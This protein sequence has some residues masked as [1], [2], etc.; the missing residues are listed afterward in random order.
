MEEALI[1]LLLG[2][3][4]VSAIVGDRIFWG[5]RKQGSPLPALVLNRISSVHSYT[6]DGPVDLSQSRIQIDCYAQTFGQTRALSRAVYAP[7]NGKRAVHE[8]VSFEGVFADSER[9]NPV[10]DDS[11]T[12]RTSIDFM[13]WSK[14]IG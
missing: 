14:A 11:L 3:T 13:V 12:F 8:G 6:L 7:L 2:D 4:G 10:E 5:L 9:D 1:S